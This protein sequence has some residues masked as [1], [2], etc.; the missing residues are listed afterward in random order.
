MR[1]DGEGDQVTKRTR[2]EVADVQ[3]LVDSVNSN[4]GSIAGGYAARIIGA[5][6]ER[7]ALNR[8]S[9]QPARVESR[10]SLFYNAGLQNSWFIVTGRSECCW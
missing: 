7:I 1:V 8:L 3:F 10:V 2:G 5:L 4:T 9:V 6:N